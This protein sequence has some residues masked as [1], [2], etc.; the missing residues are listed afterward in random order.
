[1]IRPTKPAFFSSSV[2]IIQCLDL[3]ALTPRIRRAGV[4]EKL[5]LV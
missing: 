3:F 4:I 1:M 5:P 2:S